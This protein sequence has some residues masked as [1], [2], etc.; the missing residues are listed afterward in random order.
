VDTGFERAVVTGG[1]GFLSSPSAAL[2]EAECSAGRPMVVHGGAHLPAAVLFDRDDTLI[3]DVPYNGDPE[4]VRPVPG[5]VAALA[6]LREAGVP[7]GV[8]SN[9][10]GVARGLITTDQ[11]A[12]VNSRIEELLGTF[13]TWQI[14]LHD[15]AAGCGCRKPAPGLI[16]KAAADLG[17]STVGCVVIGDIG[18]DIEAARAVGARGILVPTART[19]PAEIR[20]APEVAADLTA[21]VRLALPGRD[22]DGDPS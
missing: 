1:A 14:C 18:T 15:E 19:L 11:V 22:S 17:V 4:A 8:V 13:D 5:A 10:S 7:I 16:E 3:H 6:R 2:G 21:A 20:N 12:A 9:Q